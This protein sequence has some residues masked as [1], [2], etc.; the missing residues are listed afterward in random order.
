MY[1]PRFS[2]SGNPVFLL[3]LLGCLTAGYGADDQEKASVLINA[4]MSDGRYVAG[5]GD[6]M[7][8]GLIYKGDAEAIKSITS[9]LQG[10]SAT[11]PIKVLSIK[12]TSTGSLLGQ[13]KK[14]KIEALYIHSSMARALSSLFQVS[15]GR[16]IPSLCD[17]LAFV[18]KGGALGVGS[19]GKLVINPR[20][21]SA[22]GLQLSPEVLSKAKQ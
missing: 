10:Q 3:V 7:T 15:R 17:D 16:K 13:V 12:F 22:E 19:D 9:A 6:E 11:V 21:L 1:P 14:D 4:V 2:I 8:I 5:L 18:R 20:V